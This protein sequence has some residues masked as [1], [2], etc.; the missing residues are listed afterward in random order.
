MNEIAICIEAALS[1][2]L[3]ARRELRRSYNP[4]TTRRTLIGRAA[5]ARRDIAIA[6]HTLRGIVERLQTPENPEQTALAHLARATE[7]LQELASRSRESSLG[8]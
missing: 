2:L 5:R 7:A 6:E 4:L 8:F 3:S 1:R